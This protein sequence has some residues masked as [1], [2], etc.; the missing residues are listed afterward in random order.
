[1]EALKTI[2]GV[3]I[4]ADNIQECKERLSLGST[5]SE[6]WKILDNNIICADALNSSHEGWKDVGYMWNETD[7]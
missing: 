3:D 2:Y 4:L 7:K 5:E 6:I 1:V